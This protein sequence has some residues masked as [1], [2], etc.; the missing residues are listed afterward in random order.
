MGMLDGILGG[1]VGAG[2][3]SVVGGFI[4]SHGGVAGIVGQLQQNGLGA[5]VSSWVGMGANLPVT[6]EQ[7][8]Q[9]LGSDKFNELASKA[10]MSPEALA[11]ALSKLLPEAI[12]KLTP[13]GVV[14]AH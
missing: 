9:A 11:G 13:K 4:D 8:H 14:P 10:G 3:A 12:D 5:T 6:P 1:V 2:M 7:I